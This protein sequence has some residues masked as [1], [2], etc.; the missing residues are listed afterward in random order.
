MN[1]T[2]R[3]I[4]DEDYRKNYFDK[5]RE[6]DS[7]KNMFIEFTKRMNEAEA[8]RK[9]TE[10]KKRRSGGV[11]V[12]GA[13]SR[14]DIIRLRRVLMQKIAEVLAGEGDVKLK[15]LQAD[16][17]MRKIASLDRILADIDRIEREQMNEKRRKQKKGQT[18]AVYLTGENLTVNR[19]GFSDLTTSGY[20][21]IST[22][23]SGVDLVAGFGAAA[24]TPAEVPIIDAL[25]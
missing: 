24:G 22:A 18:E 16:D 10:A 4:S 5:L 15:N 2:Q 23:P 20:M 6:L 14:Q 3:I 13:T 19:N 9:K 21:N 25:L 17:L 12:S 8:K 1:V 11:L 7:Q